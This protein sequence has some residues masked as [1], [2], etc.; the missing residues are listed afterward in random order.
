MASEYDLPAEWHRPQGGRNLNMLE[1]EL[2]AK[3]QS[4]WLSIAHEWLT[5]ADLRRAM[6]DYDQWRTAQSIA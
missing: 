1:R 3:A 4:V 6:A 2:S 5:T